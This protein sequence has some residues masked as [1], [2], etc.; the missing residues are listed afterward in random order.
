M[1][2]LFAHQNGNEDI[3]GFDDSRNRRYVLCVLDISANY[4]KEKGTSLRE[5]KNRLYDAG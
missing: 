1:Y 4:K 3:I 5:T 2:Y